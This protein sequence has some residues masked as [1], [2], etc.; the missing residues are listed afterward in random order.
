MDKL[1]SNTNPITYHL[2]T[3]T[4]VPLE[5]D[6]RPQPRASGPSD[7]GARLVQHLVAGLVPNGAPQATWPVA[8]DRACLSTLAIE[9]MRGQALGVGVAVQPQAENELH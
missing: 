5:L 4:S 7:R 2:S 8:P 1:R 6:M 9:A 3:V